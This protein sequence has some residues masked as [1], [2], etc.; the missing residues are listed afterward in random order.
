MLSSRQHKL[1]LH[2]FQLPNFIHD[3]ERLFRF[4]FLLKSH[5][6]K[7]HAKLKQAHKLQSGRLYILSPIVYTRSIPCLTF[8]LSLRLSKTEN[9]EAFSQNKKKKKKRPTKLKH[10]MYLKPK[11]ECRLFSSH[12]CSDRIFYCAFMNRLIVL[13]SHYLEPLSRS[14]L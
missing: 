3:T 8:S 10:Y 13:L 1:I 2:I 4:F 6:A 9:C 5:E 7:R 14:C 11:P 12:P